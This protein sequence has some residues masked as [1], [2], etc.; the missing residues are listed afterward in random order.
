MT[1][2]LGAMATDCYDTGQGGQ[3]P[4]IAAVM[5]V[6]LVALDNEKTLVSVDVP[7]D[8]GNSG[9]A[10]VAIPEA[11]PPGEYTASLSPAPVEYEVYSTLT[12]GARD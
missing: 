11:A 7:L 2:T 3:A 6:S 9:E 1:V 10:E 5:T 4:P 12:V 8:A